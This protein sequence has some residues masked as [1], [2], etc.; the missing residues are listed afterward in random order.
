MKNQKFT[1]EEIEEIVN[2]VNERGASRQKVQGKD[3]NDVDFAM[4]AASVF[5][6]LGLNEHI[7]VKWIFNPMSNKAIFTEGEQKQ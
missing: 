2:Y 5:F 3:F 7:P 4:G 6:A 1:K